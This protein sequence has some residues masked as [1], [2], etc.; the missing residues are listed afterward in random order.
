VRCVT[1]ADLPALLT[2]ASVVIYRAR[3]RPA[4]DGL[5]WLVNLIE[6]AQ[7]PMAFGGLVRD[8]GGYHDG[9]A[10]N[11]VAGRDLQA[12]PAM[13]DVIEMAPEQAL[14]LYP[15]LSNCIFR[16]ELLARCE[17]ILTGAPT[18]CAVQA[19][20]LGLSLASTQVG[21]TRLPVSMIGDDPATAGALREV[22]KWLQSMA[23]PNPLGGETGAL[24]LGWR[25]MVFLR[26]ARMSMDD[27]AGVWRWLRVL[28]VAWR[29][30]FLRNEYATR[31]DPETPRWV[32][33]IC[34]AWRGRP[35]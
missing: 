13:G 25:G 29:A 2:G 18:L 6:R 31:P 12:M 22:A 33:V 4:P 9:W 35:Y 15:A 1:A 24:P 8:R 17:P 27:G 28:G 3:E 16:P 32:H 30:G 7:T 34:R 19:S 20:V 23:Q 11:R 10:D 26:M 21:Y 5:L 14:R